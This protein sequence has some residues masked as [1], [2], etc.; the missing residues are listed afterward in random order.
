MWS[1]PSSSMRYSGTPRPCS[2]ESSCREVFQSR[3][4]PSAEAASISGSNSRCTTS[5]DDLEAAAEVDRADHRLDGVGQDR[6]LV[7]AAGGLL[8]AAELDVLAE[9]DLAGDVG[10]GAGVD[11]RGAQL[12]QPALGQVGVGAVER[13]GDDD[14]EHGVAEELQPLVGRQAAVLVGERAVRQ[15]ALEQ[16]GVQDGIPE[17]CAQLVVVGQADRVGSEDLA[18]VGLGAVLAALA[19][20]AVRQ[21]LGTAGGVG[22]GHQGRRDGL[23]LRTA[24]A[25]VA[26]RH[27]P[28]R[29]SHCSLLARCDRLRR[30]VQ[31]VLVL[32]SVSAVLL[33]SCEP[34]PPRVDRL[35]VRVVRVVRQP[36]TAL[37]AQPGT[38]VLAQRLERQCE[39]HRVPQQRL[40]VEQVVLE[41]AGL[42]VLRRRAPRSSSWSS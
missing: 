18:T 1:G 35:L 3:P 36:R 40:E 19:A 33:S 30:S 4:A 34:C 32:G 6:G 8:A 24:V 10:E 11:H 28:L 38:V 17:R 41:P 22:A 23:P 2:A 42:V 12:G 20:R 25:R 39:H 31:S 21:V 5:L 16:L 14:A 7:A 37:G 29:D 15:G 9:P 13:L 27:L 26:A